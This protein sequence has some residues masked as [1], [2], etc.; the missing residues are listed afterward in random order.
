[1]TAISRSAGQWSCAESKGLVDGHT[2]GVHAFEYRHLHVDI[3]VDF[4]V[5]LS[6]RRAKRPTDILDQSTL[7]GVGKA[8][9]SA[10]R[11]AQSKP[12]PR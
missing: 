7:V 9:K 3:V 11:R 1:V 6:R 4:D 5:V 2:L 8:T 12:S 10:S